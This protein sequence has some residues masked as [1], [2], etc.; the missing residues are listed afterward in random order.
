MTV[1]PFVINWW[2]SLKSLKVELLNPSDTQKKK[3][4]P[5]SHS[6]QY[7]IRGMM[8]IIL[9]FHVLLLLKS[10]IKITL[11]DMVFV[12]DLLH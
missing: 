6:Q 9:P 8:V 10:P 3:I 5:T 1:P 11:I 4:P 12:S 7:S 2:N